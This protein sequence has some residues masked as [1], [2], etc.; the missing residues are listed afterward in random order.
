MGITVTDTIDGAVTPNC[1]TTPNYD[2]NAVGTYT[3]NCSA[4]DSQNNT[5]HFTRT[6]TISAIDKTLLQNKFDEA[7]TKIADVK[8]VNNQ[9]KTA[10]QNK[11]NEVENA[12]N[13]QNLTETERNKLTAELDDLMGKLVRDTIPPL[14]N[15]TRPTKIISRK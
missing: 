11:I 5:S 12:L 13:N 9:A 2:A 14:F 10:L 7:K 8:V 1:T 15:P 6:I 3:V 4:T